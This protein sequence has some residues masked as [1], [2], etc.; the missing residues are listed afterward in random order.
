[1]LV[2]LKAPLLRLLKAVEEW[3]LLCGVSF[4]ILLVNTKGL[5]V[6]K[7]PLCSL[8]PYLLILANHSFTSLYI[9]HHLYIDQYLY[10]DHFLYVEH[11]DADLY[12]ISTCIFSSLTHLH[13]MEPS[14]RLLSQIP[15]VALIS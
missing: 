10:T 3:V 4:N 5:D 8:S 9:D 6:A 7:T 11:L 2:M 14:C 15:H 1:M 13:I 12:A